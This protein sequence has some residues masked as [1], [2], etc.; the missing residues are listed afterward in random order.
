MNFKIIKRE[1][2]QWDPIDL[3]NHA[4]PDQYDIE[5]REIL[6]KFQCNVDQ[7]GMMIYEVFSKAF[8]TTFTKSIDECVCIA[9]KMMEQESQP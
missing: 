7:N 4:P 3:L 5:S 8:G 6:S 2:D 9:K 1:I